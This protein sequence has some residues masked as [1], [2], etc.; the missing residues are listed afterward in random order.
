[1]LENPPTLKNDHFLRICFSNN[2]LNRLIS[3][4]A[5]QIRS[6]NQSGICISQTYLWVCFENPQT[7][8]HVTW[9][10][11]SIIISISWVLQCN[12]NGCIS[13]KAGWVLHIIR[14]SFPMRFVYDFTIIKEFIQHFWGILVM[15]RLSFFCC[16]G[17]FRKRN[18]AQ[19]HFYELH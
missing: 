1:M 8:H 3:R 6:L 15:K 7:H 10:F 12:Q 16:E 17:T 13:E 2:L 5:K 9:G 11:Q 14:N 18:M 4:L 19:F